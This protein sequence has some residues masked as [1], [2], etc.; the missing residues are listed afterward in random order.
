MEAECRA[1]PALAL[2]TRLM[3]L[4]GETMSAPGVAGTRVAGAGDDDVALTSIMD[5]GVAD[6]AAVVVTG[7]GG[8]LEENT[9]RCPCFGSGSIKPST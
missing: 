2:E 6:D 1:A 8:G 7:G 5:T 4:F 9:R 3:P